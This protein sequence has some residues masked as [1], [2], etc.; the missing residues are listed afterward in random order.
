MRKSFLQ[1]SI[2]S[3]ILIL[4]FTFGC[5]QPVEEVAEEAAAKVAALSD[6]DVAAIKTAHDAYVQAVLAGGL[7]ATIEFYTEDAILIAKGPIIQG[8]E[9]IKEAFEA[10]SKASPTI[11]TFNL[12]LDEIDGRDDLALVRGMVS[13]TM[14]VEGATEPIQATGKFLEI[15]RKQE[16]GL[17]LITIDF[18]ISE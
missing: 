16:D 8:R 13:M 1:I 4:C 3:L 11:T 5:Q 12:T 2:F 18:H 6:E 17:W 15:L 14:E 10:F 7:G 9:A